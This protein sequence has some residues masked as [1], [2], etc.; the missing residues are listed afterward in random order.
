M[1]KLKDKVQELADIAK[2]VP[3]N[4]Q[5]VCFEV[6]LRNHLGA[7]PARPPKDAEPS[8]ESLGSPAGPLPPVAGTPPG[9]GGAKQEDLKSTDLHV[10]A[11]KFLQK[12]GVA[13]E[14]LNNL[15]FKEGGEIKPLYDDLKTTRMSES[16]I[17]VTLL[18]ALR[19]AITT[20][21]FEAAV[22]AVRQECD[23]RKCLDTN[24]F[25]N[26]FNNNKTLFDFE[27]FM[28]GVASVRLS[29]GGR[30]EL[31]EAIKELQ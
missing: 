10:K 24:N 29:E 25:S 12:Y 23:E 15:F 7:A 11:K 28:K 6:L 1:S 20:G 3:E 27:K 30:K 18:I 22:D 19:G 14:Q 17:R 16:Q 5:V 2:S 8:T 9:D 26:N 21:E 4:M 13:L 31:A